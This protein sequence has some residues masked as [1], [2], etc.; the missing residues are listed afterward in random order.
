MPT[1]QEKLDGVYN[2]TVGNSQIAFIDLICQRLLDTEINKIGG[3]KTSLR[4]ETAWAAANN[5]AIPASV[6][7]QSFTTA[8]GTVTNL[9]GILDKINT[10]PGAG[11]VTVSPLAAL[12]TADVQALATAAA[13]EADRRARTRLGAQL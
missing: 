1:N 10:K 3:G 9:A 2:N 12:S 13:D 6:L 11:A 4:I 7:N 8:D 5:K